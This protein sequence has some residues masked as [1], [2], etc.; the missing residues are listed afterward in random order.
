MSEPD[1]TSWP[2][3]LRRE[4][5]QYSLRGLI[6]QTPTFILS[7][8]LFV[9]LGPLTLNFLIATVIL[10]ASFCLIVVRRY[11]LGYAAL[12]AL[13]AGFIAL[14]FFSTYIIASD[15]MTIRY[16]EVEGASYLELP[17]LIARLFPRSVGE[18]R[19]ISISSC[20]DVKMAR[21]PLLP[22]TIIRA[23]R[24]LFHTPFAFR[25][26]PPLKISAVKAFVETQ[27][28][29]FNGQRV[30]GAGF[31]F[32]SDAYDSISITELFPRSLTCNY[33]DVPL[34]PVLELLP[35]DPDR[36][37]N[38]VAA[39]AK[40]STLRQTY[41]NNEMT[42]HETLASL[43]IN[44][45]SDDPYKALLDYTTYSLT[46][47]ALQ[48]NLFAEPK[49]DLETRLC[50]IVESAKRAFSGPFYQL[51]ERLVFQMARRGGRQYY[52][53]YP[54]C[55]IPDDILSSANSL[56]H[57]TQDS[58]QLES[59]LY[60]C[61]ANAKSA[62]ALRSCVQSLDFSMPQGSLN[63]RCE[64]LFC[65]TTIHG[66]IPTEDVLQ[67]YEKQF[68][69]YVLSENGTLVPLD[70]Y[71]RK[72]CPKLHNRQEER[73][74]VDRRARQAQSILLKPFKCDADDWQREF[75]ESL[76]FYK[77]ILKCQKQ[78]GIEPDA[79]EDSAVTDFLAWY[80]TRCHTS[81]EDMPEFKK[82]IVTAAKDL[83]SS[84][85]SIAASV[86]HYAT[87]LGARRAEEISRALE[88]LGHTVT[89]ACGDQPLDLCI[90]AYTSSD[91][92]EQLLNS[93][94][95]ML[96][97][98]GYNVTTPVKP[99]IKGIYE[100]L[101]TIDS[102]IVKIA[103]CD[104]LAD[105]ELSDEVGVSR[106]QFCVSHG[107]ARHIAVA[108]RYVSESHDMELEARPELNYRERYG[109]S[110]SRILSPR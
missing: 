84:A 49:A 52:T 110:R 106:E 39:A 76:S 34:I 100:A 22:Y 68:N 92:R 12:G 50:I 59:G 62:E 60:E 99:G 13:L 8:F 23:D 103:L 88:M 79:S 2:E 24:D 80:D 18:H 32:N 48:G 9:F 19:L 41:L 38:L 107:L 85:D 55:H 102:L 40:I 16:R 28:G 90:Q 54:G 20:D 105:K 29:R 26:L 81:L 3:W 109:V 95:M 64:K 46:L 44:A 77:S 10:L 35:W 53:I 78:R 21:L 82:N 65:S 61:G 93:L 43:D 63:E 94:T 15:R 25:R 31:G 56:S 33:L 83:A 101:S 69:D 75:S 1:H 91:R 71:E 67:F 47:R 17:E 27:A 72:D 73:H 58:P 57:A 51:Y 108:D 4:A 45:P 14:S 66:R 89:L 87:W 36:I 74:Y 70:A 7:S 30:F 98:N 96:A 5:I 86:R 6:F 97:R 11:V 42:T 37:D 104:G